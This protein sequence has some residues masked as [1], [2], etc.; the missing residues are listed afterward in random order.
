MDTRFFRVILFVASISV[1]GISSAQSDFRFYLQE[2]PLSGFQGVQSFAIGE[3]AGL[4]LVAGGRTDGLHRRQPF[5]SFDAAGGNNKLQVVNPETGQVWSVSTAALPASVAE[6][7]AATNM[8]FIQ[9][10][11]ILYLIGGYGYSALEGD[12]ITFPFIIAI[13][14]PGAIQAVQNGI[15]PASYIRQS[16]PDERIRVTGGVLTEL[17]GKLYLAGGHKFMGRYNP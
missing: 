7:L 15:L 17:Y 16:A 1:T 5:A 6:Q 12:H 10:D 2:V 13:D 4:W 3:H 11:T 9:R 8:Q 14:L